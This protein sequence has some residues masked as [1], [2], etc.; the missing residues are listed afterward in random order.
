MMM[1]VCVDE[2]ASWMTSSRLGL[3]LS[4]SEVL[5]CSST[6]CQHRILSNPLSLGSVTIALV[7]AVLA[8]EVHADLTFWTHINAVVK[9]SFAVLRQIRSVRRCLPRHALLMLIRSLVSKVNYCN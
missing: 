5:W 7:T 3:N 9:S 6:L 4:K 2:V 1:F 8:L